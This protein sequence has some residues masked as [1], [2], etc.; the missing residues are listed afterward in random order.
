MIRKTGWSWPWA[1]PFRR[2]ASAPS[3]R[4]L[5]RR[6]EHA[7]RSRITRGPRRRR[8]QRL[9]VVPARGARAQG[10]PRR[11]RR[12]PRRR[13]RAALRRLACATCSPSAGACTS[14]PSAAA[15]GRARSATAPTAT[16]LVVRVPPGTQVERWDGTRYD[17]VRAGQ[18]VTVARG[19]SGGRG[20][21]RFKSLDAPDAAARRARAAGRGG[22]RRAAPQAAR[23]RRPRRAAERRQV[24][25][26]RRASRAR[27][28][29]SPTTRSR[30]SSRCSA[31]SRRTTASS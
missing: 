31:R 1:L 12:R 15:T 9:P 14:G 30:R 13:R 19:G 3:A 29:R 16:T 17:L 8:R 2:Q 25:A 20:N 28:R 7:H 6:Y 4:C 5:R 21:T 26:A 24:V 10:R 18:E 22:A 11:R 27:S 23:R